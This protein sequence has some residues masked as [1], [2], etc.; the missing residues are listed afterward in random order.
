MFSLAKASVYCSR[1][2]PDESHVALLDIYLLALCLDALDL[3]ICQPAFCRM[4]LAL[5]VSDLVDTSS[6]G[7]G[8]C[9]QAFGRAALMG[10]ASVLVGTSSQGRD[11]YLPASGRAAFLVFCLEA[12]GRV[13]TSS[14]QT[15]L[16]DT[17]VPSAIHQQ[18]DS[19]VRSLATCRILLVP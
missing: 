13:D 7:L 19:L 9:L 3:D 12:F 15:G 1:R 5:K 16:V 2:L 14:E 8:I 17:L 6:L 10:K 4:A 11:I 18:R